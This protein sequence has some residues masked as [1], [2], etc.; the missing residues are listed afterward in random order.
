VSSSPGNSTWEAA[1][2]LLALPRFFGDRLS[3]RL[4][5]SGYHSDEVGAAD[6]ADDLAVANHHHPLDAVQIEEPGDRFGRRLEGWPS[7][8][9]AS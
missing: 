7:R 5:R 1:A 3:F 8:C 4:G 2:Q 9:R 6:D